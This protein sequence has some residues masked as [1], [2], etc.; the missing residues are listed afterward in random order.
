MDFREHTSI[1]TPNDQQKQC[2]NNSKQMSVAT[3]LATG[4]QLEK[5]LAWIPKNFFVDCKFTCN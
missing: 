5:G 1:G 2:S 3:T 4:Q